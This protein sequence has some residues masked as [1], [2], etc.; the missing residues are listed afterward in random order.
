MGFATLVL[1]KVEYIYRV[2][3]TM[4]CRIET[5]HVDIT[6]WC[7]CQVALCY[8]SA[9]SAQVVFLSAVCIRPAADV[10]SLVV[11]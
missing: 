10:S 7:V 9:A 5:V 8:T 6:G 1:A 2:E 11:K 4:I 3:L